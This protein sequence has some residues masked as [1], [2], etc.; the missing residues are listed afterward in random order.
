VEY[1]TFPLYFGSKDLGYQANYSCMSGLMNEGVLLEDSSLEVVDSEESSFRSW[2]V[3]SL[4]RWDINGRYGYG[5]G[6]L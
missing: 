5:Q 2:R 6:C 4:K 3:T 1:F